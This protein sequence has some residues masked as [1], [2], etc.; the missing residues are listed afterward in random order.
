MHMSE[1][2]IL[3]ISHTFEPC[4]RKPTRWFFNRYDT[5]QAV[6][7]QKMAR[8][9]KFWIQKV[10]ELYCLCSENKGAVTAK[11]ICTFVFTYGK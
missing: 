7:A 1:L 3:A 11:L 10:E 6:Q 2:G 5:N 4:M 9:W 8:G